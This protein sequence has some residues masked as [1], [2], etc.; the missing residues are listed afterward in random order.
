MDGVIKSPGLSNYFRAKGSFTT[1]RDP[2]GEAVTVYAM[3][4]FDAYNDLI[5][6][7]C[8]KSKEV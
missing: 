8:I 5:T 7:A 4:D 1:G 3:T 6:V 2:C